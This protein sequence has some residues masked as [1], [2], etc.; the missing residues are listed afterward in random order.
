MEN[1]RDGRVKELRGQCAGW[2]IHTDDDT[3]KTCPAHPHP[4]PH[5]VLV[6]AGLCLL[7]VLLSTLPPNPSFPSSAPCSHL[8][9]SC[10]LHLLLCD[11]PRPWPRLMLSLPFFPP[12]STCSPHP[13]LSHPAPLIHQLYFYSPRCALENTIAW[14][15]KPHIHHRPTLPN[16]AVPGL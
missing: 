5:P 15:L 9:P 2:R 4:L 11:L 8:I 1:V 13:P 6:L 12:V 10:P 7:P 16:F 14:W 3:T